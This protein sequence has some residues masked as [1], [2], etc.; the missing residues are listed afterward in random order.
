[1]HIYSTHDQQWEL[2]SRPIDLESSALSTRL[3]ASTIATNVQIADVVGMHKISSL[4]VL[5]MTID[6]L[7]HF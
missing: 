5:V 7:G 1:M 3:H 6:A 2:N 4:K